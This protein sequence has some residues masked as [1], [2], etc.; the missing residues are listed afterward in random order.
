M[1]RK[2][3]KFPEQEAFK[4]KLRPQR[5]PKERPAKLTREERARLKAALKPKST[6]ASWKRLPGSFEGGK[7]G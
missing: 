3:K 1:S 4:K 5:A 7:R 2:R 6:D